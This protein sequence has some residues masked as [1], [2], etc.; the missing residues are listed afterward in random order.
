MFLSAKGTL[1]VSTSHITMPKLL[2]RKRTRTH[3]CQKEL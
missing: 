2:Q 1:R 3:D